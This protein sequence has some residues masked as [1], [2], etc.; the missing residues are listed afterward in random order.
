M[1][2][3]NCV[4]KKDIIFVNK[5]K[6]KIIAQIENNKIEKYKDSYD[7]LINIS[8]ISL[9]TEKLSELKETYEKIKIE[10]DKVLSTTETEM[11]LQELDYL[12]KKLK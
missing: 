4:L 3:I 12:K 6:D 2:F 5:T 8:L 7:Y 10:I 9:S 11:W 1:K